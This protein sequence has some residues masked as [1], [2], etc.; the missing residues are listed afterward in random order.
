MTKQ[1]FAMAALADHRELAR[2]IA[3]LSSSGVVS[4]VFPKKSMTGGIASF[5]RPVN[6]ESIAWPIWHLTSCSGHPFGAAG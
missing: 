1:V 4:R 5:A 6:Q 3:G 2:A